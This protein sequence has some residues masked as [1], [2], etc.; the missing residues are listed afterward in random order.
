MIFMTWNCQGA[1]SKPFRRALK[2]FVR[3]YNPA[4]VCLLEPKVSGDQANSICSSFGFEE[5]I[6]VGRVFRRDMDHVEK[7]Y[8]N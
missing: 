3:M 8:N 2:M 7:Y 4:I 6:R 1:A 5:W